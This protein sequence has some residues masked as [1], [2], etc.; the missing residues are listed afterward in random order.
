MFFSIKNIRLFLEYTPTW[1]SLKK[2][3][4]ILKTRIISSAKETRFLSP[5]FFTC[6]GLLIF[7][8]SPSN[9]LNTEILLN[10]NR[11]FLNYK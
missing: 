4:I 6:L 1:R 10:K 3:L 2:V 11:Y 5:P 8:F 7:W 9:L